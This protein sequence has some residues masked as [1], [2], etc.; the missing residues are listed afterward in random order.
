LAVVSHRARGL[1]VSRHIVEFEPR[2]TW[3]PYSARRLI[4]L[5][6]A[7]GDNNRAVAIQHLACYVVRKRSAL[8]GNKISGPRVAVAT[9]SSGE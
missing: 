1:S 8:R 5:R 6:L 4:K 9:S 7:A 3:C 2:I